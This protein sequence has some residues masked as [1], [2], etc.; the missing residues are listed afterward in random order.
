MHARYQNSNRSAVQDDN[1]HTLI[2]RFYMVANKTNIF[3]CD[4][5][6]NH[7]VM[8]LLPDWITDIFKAWK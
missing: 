7:I 3:H 5:F 1:S 8:A 2:Q 4:G 6:Q